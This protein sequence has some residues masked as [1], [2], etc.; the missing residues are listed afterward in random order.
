MRPRAAMPI[1]LASTSLCLG[2]GLAAS[3]GG[4]PQEPPR[5]QGKVEQKPQARPH[6]APVV[7]DPATVRID[8]GDTV[9]IRWGEGDEETVRI[10]G[11]DTPETR[12]EEHSIP[13]DQSF[14]PEG[15]A[16]AQGAF[17]VASDVKLIRAAMLDPYGRTLGYLILDGKNYSVLVIKA[18]LSD[19]TVSFYGDNG[20]PA[21]AA[22]VKS[23]AKG[24]PPL[25]FEPPHAFRK[26]MRSVS[27]WQ[28]SPHPNPAR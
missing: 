16:F 10:L 11:I 18:G 4:S 12:H 7:V 20:L 6:G 27:D 9:V 8:D 13:Y 2:L 1:V 5:V 26:R 28:K 15:R 21:M 3:P 23:A 19:E 14:G 17:A 22:E 24:R 25:A